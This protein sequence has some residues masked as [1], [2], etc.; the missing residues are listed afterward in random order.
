MS[1]K[2]K[3]QNIKFPSSSHYVLLCFKI[4]LSANLM[5][6]IFNVLNDCDEVYNYWE[7][8][9]FISSFGKGGGFQTWEYSP[10]HGLRSY[11]YLWLFGWP[12]FVVRLFGGP[13]WIAFLLV[14]LYLALM[15]AFSVTCLA[16]VLHKL[17]DQPGFGFPLP[18]LFVGFFSL[19]PGNFLSS[20]TLVPSG[21][22][23]SLC[24]FMLAAWLSGRYS[25]T[26]FCVAFMGIVIWPFAAALGIPLALCMLF[27]KK[28]ISLVGSAIVSAILL[29]VPMLIVDSLHY[30]R[31]VLAPLNIITYNLFARTANV[32][33]SASQLYGVEPVSFYLKNYLLNYNI[34]CLLACGFLLCTVFCIPYAWLRRPDKQT[35]PSRIDVYLAC[36]L[37]LFIWNSIFFIQ[38][39]KEERFMFP[40]YPCLALG[41][42]LFFFDLIQYLSSCGRCKRTFRH[43]ATIFT[44]LVVF[45]FIL[46]G[47][48]RIST[49]IR[50]YR[51]PVYLI[52]H[53]PSK[54]LPS[55]SHTLCMGRDWHLFPS[56]FL[57]PDLDTERWWQIGFLRSNFRGQLPGQYY[58]VTAHYSL[59][60][61]TRRD[62][63]HFNTENLEEQDRYLKHGTSECDFLLDRDSPPGER[64]ELYVAQEVNWTSLVN[65]SMLEPHLCSRGAGHWLIQ[66]YPFLCSVFRSFYVPHFS[67]IVNSP[68]RMH[69]LQRVV[70]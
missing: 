12:S 43:L 55:D 29:V 5:S 54:S 68:V 20:T 23:T 2:R 40:C 38:Q 6:V 27:R 64:E 18:I 34:A 17:N 9:H 30:G 22:A 36:G 4:A 26:V 14:R 67:E 65:H 50:W 56:R 60:D 16:S 48:A 1:D 24:C 49:L 41:A 58:P 10:S 53:V 59:F 19:S 28:I 11:L 57:L 62:G 39:H 7:P 13:S 15:S 47:F 51:A 45:F 31:L 44:V 35:R 46:L 61:S 37:P 32:T 8:L 66:K 52:R 42:S 25:L 69:I 63:N 33:G 21:V 70:H 3:S